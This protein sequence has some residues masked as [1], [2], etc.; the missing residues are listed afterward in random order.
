[1]IALQGRPRA[2]FVCGV[3]R[4]KFLLLVLPLGN[5]GRNR[6]IKSDI[7]MNRKASSPTEVAALARHTHKTVYKL[8]KFFKKELVKLRGFLNTECAPLFCC[9]YK[10]VWCLL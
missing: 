9:Q 10:L 3:E 1:M 2:T 6:G 8:E 5:I 4:I 7:V